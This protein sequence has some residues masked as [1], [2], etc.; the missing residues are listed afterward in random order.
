MFLEI[1]HFV[2]TEKGKLMSNFI[3]AHY[4]GERR[5]I[6]LD[7]VEEI[8]EDGDHAIVYFGFNCPDACQ[9]DYLETDE[10]FDDISRRIWR[11]K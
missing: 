3:S 11:S 5:L 1:T 2:L 7:W 6:N 4:N 9:Q 10:S 8:H